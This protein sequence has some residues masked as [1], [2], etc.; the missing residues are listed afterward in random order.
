MSSRLPLLLW[1]PRAFAVGQR[2]WARVLD[3]E[4]AGEVRPA[5]TWRYALSPDEKRFVRVLLRRHSQLWCWRTD[6]QARAGDFALVDM[7][8]PDPANRRW[9]VVD[10]KLEAPLRR[11]GGGAGNQLVNAGRVG[12]VLATRGLVGKGTAPVLLTGDRRE[13][14][15]EIAG[16]TSARLPAR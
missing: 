7:S 5:V 16:A 14:V 12:R 10:V 3:R 15:R 8:A 11:G 9:F 2:S 4:L 6:Q 13:L 1:L